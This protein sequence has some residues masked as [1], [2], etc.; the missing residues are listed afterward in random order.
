ML[1]DGG[2]GYVVLLVVVL[3]A[4]YTYC[5]SGPMTNELHPDVIAVP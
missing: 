3:Q 5:M 1:V 4:S 2:Y